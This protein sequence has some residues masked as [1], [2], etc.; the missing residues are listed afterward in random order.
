MTTVLEYTAKSSRI[1]LPVVELAGLH[2]LGI[3]EVFSLGDGRYAFLTT[4]A[5]SGASVC[6]VVPDRATA[7]ITLRMFARRGVSFVDPNLYLYL[8]N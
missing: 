5:Q 8:Y 2:P 6:D 3:V 4:S 1:P 7:L